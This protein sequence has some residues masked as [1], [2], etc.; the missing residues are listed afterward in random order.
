MNTPVKTHI[1]TAAQVLAQQAADHNK[2]Q[3]NGG[4]TS[5]A[6]TSNDATLDAFMLEH[7]GGG[8]ATFFKF[9][10]D[11]K[12][13]KTSDGEEIPIGTELTAVYDAIQGGFI[14]FNG[15]GH[16]PTRHMG[17]LFSGF[18][19][20]KRETLGDDDPSTWEIGPSGKPADPWQV[21]ML[22][23][24]VDPKTNELFIFNTTSITGRGA[25]GKLI[26]AC[27]R[28]RQSDPNSYP[29][30]RLDLG[31]FEHRDPRIGWVTT[32]A[33]PVVGKGPKDGTA[34]PDTSIAADMDDAIPF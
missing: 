2:P 24:L 27:K 6:P 8:G 23:P 26:L 11:G 17:P 33:F 20:P 13:R 16:P 18:I 22:L 21:Q 28:M 7:A 29:V 25:V 12:Y 4:G 3:P 30:V 32:P 15:K 1:P 5:V 14:R 10:K 31:G 19:A 34:V 9:A